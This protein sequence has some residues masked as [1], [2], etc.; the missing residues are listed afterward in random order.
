MASA[1][2]TKED[3]TE[4]LAPV[5]RGI[6]ANGAGIQA[7]GAALQAVVEGKTDN[8]MKLEII[9]N[10]LENCPD[11]G[12]TPQLMIASPWFKEQNP[13][14]GKE[15]R[16]LATL[17]KSYG[18]TGATELGIIQCWLKKQ[19][20]G[21]SP[22]F[23]STAN[24]RW[25]HVPAAGFAPVGLTQAQQRQQL[26]AAQRMADLEQRQKKKAE[27]DAA[28]KKKAE[29]DAAAKKKAEEDAA[30]GSGDGDDDGDDTPDPPP[31]DD[32]A[33]DD[34]APDDD[35]PDPPPP[36]DDA[37]KPSG[38]DEDDDEMS[39]VSSDDDEEKGASG[40]GAA[41]VLPP[42]EEAD[43][44]GPP[45][46]SMDSLLDH[47]KTHT[48]RIGI[49]GATG[50]GK[51]RI[52]TH[53]VKAIEPTLGSFPDDS[54]ASGITP[55]TLC[56]FTDNETV[57]PKHYKD[58][59]G[60]DDCMTEY[61]EVASDWYLAFTDE[62]LKGRCRSRLLLMDDAPESWNSVKYNGLK[63][64]RKSARESRCTVIFCNH[65]LVGDGAKGT[66]FRGSFCDINIYLG[67]WDKHGDVGCFQKQ[68]KGKLG[69]LEPTKEYFSKTV[70]FIPG[71]PTAI[72]TVAT[73]D[74][75]AMGV[76]RL[77]L[78]PEPQEPSP[79]DMRSGM[80]GG[81][82]K[83]AIEAYDT[84][85]AVAAENAE[86]NLQHRKWADKVWASVD[87][88]FEEH[89]QCV[90]SPM[91]CHPD[92]YTKQADGTYVDKDGIPLDEDYF[93]YMS[94]TNMAML[95]DGAADL[96]QLAEADHDT[97]WWDKE[98]IDKG[99]FF[100][101]LQRIDMEDNYR[102]GF[103][104]FI[105][106]TDGKFR[107]AVGTDFLQLFYWLKPGGDI[108]NPADMIEPRV[109][110][111]LFNIGLDYDMG[112][113]WTLADANKHL[114]HIKTQHQKDKRKEM[115]RKAKKSKQLKQKGK[116]RAG[117]ASSS[118]RARV[119]RVISDEDM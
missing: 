54:D 56:L 22:S 119:G 65:A 18:G 82:A 73:V 40:G 88:Y 51:S 8:Q 16:T 96:E 48:P 117:G 1:G 93:P 14:E 85:M 112:D 35:A 102:R 49:A 79:G 52:V 24:G 105:K 58:L 27:E 41:T 106:D 11:D 92:Y 20:T 36:D 81:D 110:R 95:E 29:E 86:I 76:F 43:D 89:H 53:I 44:G 107:E 87:Y 50:K 57:W 39:D 109:P 70:R 31:P 4:A 6:Q 67:G 66:A 101:D 64:M 63:K 2:I 118:K 111:I 55:E 37:P 77:R 25:G 61:A 91:S 46:I 13:P 72:Q 28:A 75:D 98:D 19:A 113:E 104:P 100:S 69:A 59:I 84:E 32:D 9:N 5:L 60:D 99:E 33:L 97:C 116:Q 23:A 42:T 68:L 26:N 7:N 34:D 47:V 12:Y 38:S 108:G 74:I 115:K 15:P 62:R 114:L 45:F 3:L 21:K 17:F 103:K 71:V 30:G 83:L 90:A 80:C 78:F 94:A 10:L